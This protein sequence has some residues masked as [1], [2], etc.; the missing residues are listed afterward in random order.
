MP[1]YFWLLSPVPFWLFAI[2]WNFY[3]NSGKRTDR[4]RR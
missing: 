3:R 2:W 4:L 1:W